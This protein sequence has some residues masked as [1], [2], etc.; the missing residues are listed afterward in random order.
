[1]SLS[2]HDQ[3]LLAR[4][5]ALSSSA[6]SLGN[7]P[8]GSVIA[9]RDGH[10]L[11]EGLNDECTSADPTGHAEMNVVRRIAGLSPK[12]LQ[13]ATIYASGE[14]CAMCAAAIYWAGIRRLVYAA[15]SQYFSGLEGQS[16]DVL[17]LSCRQVLFQGTYT[18]EVIGPVSD[19]GAEAVLRQAFAT[20]KRQ[21]RTTP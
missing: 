8:F 9:D 14:P 5:V 15:S 17:K 3:Q 20:A 18:S 11:A 6:L 12:Q 2:A 16:A 7:R 4:T 1:M 13:D 19:T 21:V 10:I